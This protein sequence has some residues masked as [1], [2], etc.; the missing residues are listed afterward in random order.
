MCQLGLRP[1][2]AELIASPILNTNRLIAIV[3]LLNLGGIVLF[4][5]YRGRV[6]SVSQFEAPQV[7]ATQEIGAKSVPT[8]APFVIP[9]R[10]TAPV[11]NSKVAQEIARLRSEAFNIVEDLVRR[12]KN[13]PEA[14]CLLGKLHLRRGNTEVAR[15]IWDYALKLDPN[16][17]EALLD[18]GNAELLLG[19]QEKAEQYFRKAISSAK[20]PTDA[21]LALGKVLLDEGKMREAV[22]QLNLLL[23]RNARPAEA[24]CKLGLAHQ[25]LGDFPAALTDY[26]K[27]LQLEKN[28]W[29]AILGMQTAYR[30]LGDTEN[31]T[32]YTQLLSDPTQTNAGR[33]DGD[34]IDLD[35]DKAIEYFS[36]VSQTA[37]N[38]LI[39]AADPASA[40]ATLEKAN[41]VAPDSDPIR[42][43][44]VSV[45]ARQGRDADAIQLLQSR[46]VQSPRSIN[47][48]MDLAVFCINARRLDVAESA[49]RKSIELAPNRAEGYSLLSQIQMTKPNDAG[50]AVESAKRALSLSPVASNH[51]IL[52]T[53]MYHA[54]DLLGARRELTEAIRLEPSNQEFRE[55]LAQLPE[56]K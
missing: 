38:I 22:E 56:P 30:S 26:S 55:A 14:L 34:R 43:Q 39:A 40:I 28:S 10:P 16:H 47:A 3:I 41:G 13:N 7:N 21:Q 11:I 6:A 15:S 49:L 19:D 23:K 17:S 2:L 45:Y 48:W 31:A 24:W 37:S 51:Y 32:K 50:L 1:L 35:K 8:L 5:L 29:E 46:C 53:A 25:Q 9:D 54:K 20:D 27:A 12:L 18:M 36:F 42:H 44:L 52:A 4:A 33:T